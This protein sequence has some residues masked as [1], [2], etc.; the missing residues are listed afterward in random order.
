MFS[1]LVYA[2]LEIVPEIHSMMQGAAGEQYEVRAR[3]Y[4]VQGVEAVGG[5]LTEYLACQLPPKTV[6]SEFHVTFIIPDMDC[7]CICGIWELSPEYLPKKSLHV[8]NDVQLKTVMKSTFCSVFNSYISNCMMYPG[9]M[10]MIS[11]LYSLFP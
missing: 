5:V 11:S 1:L 10:F 7:G 2:L 6:L 4:E 8:A 3:L 9:P